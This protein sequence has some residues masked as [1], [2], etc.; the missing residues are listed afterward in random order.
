M[1]DNAI[2]DA[3]DPRIPGPTDKKLHDF[4]RPIVAVDIALLTV[5][6]DRRQLLVVEMAR[7]NTGKWALPGRFLRERETL[8]EAVERC[9]GDKLGVQGVRPHQLAVFDDPYRDDRDWVISVAHVA[10]VRPEQIESLGS[11]SAAT[12]L[13]SVDRPGELV[14]DH[15]GI[16]RLAKEH[17]RSRY[18][19]E[20]DPDRLLGPRFT[21]S[22]LQRV[23]EAVA[24][25]DDLSRYAFRR[26]MKDHLV[27]TGD[28]NEHTGSRGRP[29]E[30]FRRKRD[31]S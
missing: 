7:K 26:L 3:A 5:D 23:H 20:A 27:S 28:F 13:V 4:P 8:A 14:W 2:P 12:R 9:L 25:H 11:G 21:L 15:P 16:V 31:R 6:P 30:L 1:G 24:G 19:A 22:E 29:A 10:V 18:E 17:V